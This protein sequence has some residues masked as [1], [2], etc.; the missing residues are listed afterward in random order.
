ML[1]A[2][3]GPKPERLGCRAVTTIILVVLFVLFLVLA[4]CTCLARGRVDIPTT[5]GGAPAPRAD[6]FPYWAKSLPPAKAMFTELK[7]AIFAMSPT[8]EGP[9][10]TRT[11]PDDYR[12]SDSISNH[13]TEEVRIDCRAGNTP[14]PREAWERMAPQYRGSRQGDDMANRVGSK[15]DSAG[16]KA[17]SADSKAD[18]ADSKAGAYYA[19]DAYDA[20]REKVYGAT[21]E[22]NIFNPAFVCWVLG[23]TVGPGAKVLDPS[24]GWGDRLIGALASGAK[25]Y[26]GFDPNPRLQAGYEAIV[27]SLCPKKD[28]KNFRVTEAPFEDAD[29]EADVYDIAFTSPPYYAYEEYVAPGQ[30]GQEAQSIGRYPD[31]DTW[32]RKMYRPYLENA[33]RAV[34]P[35]GWVVLYIEDI[36][37]EGQRYPLRQ[38]TQTIMESLGAEPAMN[39]GLSVVPSARPTGGGGGGGGGRRRKRKPERA[40]RTRW[41]LGWRKCAPPDAASLSPALP[42]DASP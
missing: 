33:F 21:R 4:A 9:I 6:D 14:T 37:F 32:A 23:E 19:Y 27:G 38:L 28:R 11:Y 42:A 31:Y 1:R 3:T 26:E 40:P 18:S 25:S 15:A 17:D 39:F 35:G 5:T 29:L 7:D 2:P 22:C 12:R 30:A 16:S 8:G 41:A 13:F 34:R 24:S 10:L 36:R 20:L